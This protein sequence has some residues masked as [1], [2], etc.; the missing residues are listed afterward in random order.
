MS[1]GTIEFLMKVA[2]FIGL[3]GFVWYV[4]QMTDDDDDD[5]PGGVA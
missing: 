2:V 5:F 4:T 1:D 3:I